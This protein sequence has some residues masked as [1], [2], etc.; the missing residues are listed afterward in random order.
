MDSPAGRLEAV[1]KRIAGACARAGREPETVTLVG[2]SKTLPAE[3]VREM[4]QAGLH[5]LGENRVQE[6]REKIPAVGLEARWHLIGHLQ[7]NKANVAARLFDFVHS[8]DSVEI[9]QRL[10]RAAVAAG[11]RLTGLVQVDLAGE[12]QKSGVATAQLDEVLK[13]AVAADALTVRGLMILP[14]LEEDPERA[15]PWF[16][17]LR[18]LR[19]EAAGRHPGLDLGMLSMGMSGD[20]AVAIEEGATHVRVGRALFGERSGAR[21][22]EDA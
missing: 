17:R 3:R 4:V 15:R 8:I 1:R 16:R 14:P 22:M 10:D 9:L 2:V 20:F 18:A 11:R 21:T 5:D 12:A 13:A 7:G 19:D 6:A